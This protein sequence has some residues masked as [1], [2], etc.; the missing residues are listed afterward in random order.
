MMIKN[1]PWS[2]AGV[3]LLGCL[4]VNSCKASNYLK[5]NFK[6]SIERQIIDDYQILREKSACRGEKTAIAT[7][8]LAIIFETQ[9]FC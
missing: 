3:L 2:L 7:N 6:D 4:S 5:R 9:F 1:S 8:M